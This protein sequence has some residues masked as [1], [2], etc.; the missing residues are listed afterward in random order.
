MIKDFIEHIL[1]T[2]PIMLSQAKNII[3]ILIATI[4]TLIVWE[5]KHMLK[6][7]AVLG[8]MGTQMEVQ[9]TMLMQ[10]QATLGDHH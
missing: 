10:C 2:I 9:Q 3:V 4:K 8:V 6:C 7:H 5:Q 1:Y